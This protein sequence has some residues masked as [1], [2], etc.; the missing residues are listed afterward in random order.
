MPASYL[1]RPQQ[2][3][4][5]GGTWWCMPVISA[6]WEDHCLEARRRWRRVPDLSE[7]GLG[8]WHSSGRVLA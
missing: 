6:T 1:L 3:T 4:N 5:W 8:A 7:K 2:R